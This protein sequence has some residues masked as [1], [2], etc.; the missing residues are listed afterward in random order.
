L[1]L[2]INGSTYGKGFTSFKVEYASSPTATEWFTKGVTL[3]NPTTEKRNEVLATFDWSHLTD[4]QK[5]YIK[6]TTI[7][8]QMELLLE[9]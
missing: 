2:L 5:Y 7:K 8:P 9:F 6:V 3:H 1:L 4:L